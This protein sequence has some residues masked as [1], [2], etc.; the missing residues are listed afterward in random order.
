[1]SKIAS[2]IERRVPAARMAAERRAVLDHT[3][4]APV[5]P[6]EVRDPVDVGLRARRD[7]REAHRGQRRER[8][9]CRGRSSRARRGR[10]ARGSSPFDRVL[11]DPGREAV[12][13]DEDQLLAVGHG[14]PAS[15]A[16][17][18]LVAGEAAQA[19]VALGLAAACPQREQQHHDRL[20]VADDRERTRARRA[21][22]LPARSGSR[23]PSAC[24]HEPARR[25]R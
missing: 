5:V 22:A 20:E 12:D 8:A 4:L 6:D 16:V 1:M 15:N 2:R 14:A 9:R 3:P 17:R 10:P 21:R 23:S 19:R 24:R 11:E 7:R 25:G 13:D 18:P